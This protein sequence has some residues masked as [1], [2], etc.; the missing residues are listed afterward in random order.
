[1]QNQI[2]A[3]LHGKEAALSANVLLALPSSLGD[4]SEVFVDGKKWSR[5]QMPADHQTVKSEPLQMIVWGHLL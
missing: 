3:K 4:W 1:M 5:A 2:I